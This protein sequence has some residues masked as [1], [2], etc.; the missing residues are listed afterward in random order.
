MRGDILISRRETPKGRSGNPGRSCRQR[1][2]AA[3]ATANK[4]T[5]VISPAFLAVKA[6][7][8]TAAAA[9]SCRAITTLQGSVLGVLRFAHGRFLKKRENRPGRACLGVSWSLASVESA[10]L[11]LVW[12]GEARVGLGWF[13]FVWRVPS[14]FGLVWCPGTVPLPPPERQSEE[15]GILVKLA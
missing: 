1:S 13:G 6:D 15:G 5:P 4:T 8:A 10:W 14:R 9:A 7:A 12:G 11:G 3:A 2:S